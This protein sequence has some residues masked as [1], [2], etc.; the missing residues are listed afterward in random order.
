MPPVGDLK[1]VHN[2]FVTVNESV[3]QAAKNAGVL[4]YN[5]A[6]EEAFARSSCGLPLYRMISITGLPEFGVPFHPTLTGH[7]NMSKNVS[8]LYEQELEAR[9]HGK[10]IA[11]QTWRVGPGTKDTI[12]Y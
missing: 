12:L 9:R 7:W 11:R 2:L 4:Y 3:R 6:S 10:S 8:S 1:F 5:P